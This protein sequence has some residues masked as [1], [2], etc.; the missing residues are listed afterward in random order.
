MPPA[1]DRAR[2]LVVLTATEARVDGRDGWI[3]KI[4]IYDNGESHNM[5][6]HM[7]GI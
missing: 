3:T 6:L 7:Y 4:N 5:M 1:A 2:A